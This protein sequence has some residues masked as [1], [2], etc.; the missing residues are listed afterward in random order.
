MVKKTS[1]GRGSIIGAI[2]AILIGAAILLFVA[3]MVIN[4]LKSVNSF[5]PID[6]DPSYTTEQNASHMANWAE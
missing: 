6:K 5:G 4:G 1:I 2:G 3:T